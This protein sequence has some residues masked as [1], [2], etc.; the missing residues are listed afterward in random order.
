MK[1]PAL[2]VWLLVLALLLP[3]L[4]AAEGIDEPFKK[5]ETAESWSWGRLFSWATGQ[6]D[7]RAGKS[8]ALVIG[9]SAYSNGIAPLQYTKNDPI[10]MRDFLLD[11]EGFDYVHVLTEEKA[12][13]R[14]IRQLMEDELPALI[15]ENDRFLFYWSGHGIDFKDGTGR[16]RGYLPLA[17]SGPRQRSSMVSMA[18]LDAWDDFINVRHALYLLDACASGLA[19]YEVQGEEDFEGLDNATLERLS[20][21]G[22]HLITAGTGE[23]KTI[24]SARW[25]GSVFTD[26]ILRAA[27]G[28]ADARTAADPADG[29]VSLPELLEYVTKRVDRERRIADFETAITPKWENLRDDNEG[30]FFFITKDK[31]TETAR[32][33]GVQPTG[34]LKDG[35]PVVVEVQGERVEPGGCDIE[36]DRLLW[37]TIRDETEPVYFQDYLDRF[38]AG[39]ICGRFAIVAQQRVGAAAGPPPEPS[40]HRSSRIRGASGMRRSC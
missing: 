32:A 24:A 33:E 26:S 21:P 7:F 25:E 40:R 18:Q 38:N 10:R 19:S 5:P 15:G 35:R 13:F 28:E 2:A 17:T 6:D 11:E 39:E 31:K 30:G 23:Q 34:E 16:A 1:R 3:S 36:T 22:R 9:I 27:R 29:V 37:E 12:T 14:R 8:Y 4:A 20:K